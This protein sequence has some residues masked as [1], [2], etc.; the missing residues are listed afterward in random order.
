[1]KTAKCYVDGS[2]NPEIGKYAFGCV[3]IHEDESIEEY[4]GSGNSPEA[5]LQRNVAG[6]MIAAML[7][8]KWAIVNE[9]EQVNI[10]YDYYGIECWVTGAWKAKNE[11]TQK[12]RDWMRE[13]QRYISIGFNKVAAH[14]NDKYNEMA[15]RLAKEGLFQECG[16]PEISKNK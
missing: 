10:F 1:M 11:L 12:Y 14:T 6:E 7:A 15:D 4:K 13:K 5:L 8:V 16:I 9:Y 2:F 3:M